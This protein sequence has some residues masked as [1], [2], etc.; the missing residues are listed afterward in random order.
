MYAAEVHVD[1]GKS[2]FESLIKIRYN[3]WVV[4]EMKHVGVV[5]AYI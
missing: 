3:H 4:G 5:K 1:L 2:M